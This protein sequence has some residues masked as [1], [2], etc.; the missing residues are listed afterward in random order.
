MGNNYV[1]NQDGIFLYSG[2]PAA[3]NLSGSWAPAPG[4]DSYGN[5]YPA[6]INVH[7][8]LGSVIISALDGVFRSTGHTG[9][10]VSV[11]DGSI[12]LSRAGDA[13]TAQIWIRQD[14]GLVMRSGAV[15]FGDLVGGFEIL[16]STGINSGDPVTYPR[17]VTA[18]SV[19]TDPAM[20]LVSGAVVKSDLTGTVA[21]TWHLPAYNSGWSAATSFGT[22]TGVQPL[23]FRKD[24][25]DRVWIEGAFTAASGA[26]T[27]IF[28]L[29][30]DFWPAYQSPPLDLT[31]RTSAGVVTK[32]S[33]MI[34]AT[35]GNFSLNTNLGSVVAAGSVYSV[36]GSYPLGNIN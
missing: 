18:D 26:G 22:L 11:Q 5:A 4:T 21:E 8:A 36:S 3:G 2:T 28:K 10:I 29:P 30:P 17:T 7:S 19:G 23:H 1:V 9:N 24:A 33:A 31:A 20:H 15:A 25:Q 27:A 34:S 12:S 14:D 16:G 32:S 35:T 13:S 6:G